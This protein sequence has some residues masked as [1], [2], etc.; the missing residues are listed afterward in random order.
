MSAVV[1]SLPRVLASTLVVLFLVLPVFLSLVVEA[2]HSPE[3]QSR[4]RELF[5]APKVL[6]EWLSEVGRDDLRVLLDEAVS[7]SNYSLMKSVV[8]R[9]FEYLG[10]DYPVTL[11][12]GGKHLIALKILNKSDDLSVSDRDLGWLL[13]H[14]TKVLN[15][16]DYSSLS[17]VLLVILSGL[18]VYG[19][20]NEL[21]YFMVYLMREPTA[22][23]V[24][25][26]LR[27]ELRLQI[28]KFLDYVESGAFKDA[29]DLSVNVS[30]S[31][32]I[33]LGSC[34]YLIATS[35]SKY[36]SLG[37]LPGGSYDTALSNSTVI[38]E[39]LE[40]LMRA[41]VS[42][43]LIDIL[44]RLPPEDLNRLLSD[45]N[46]LEEIDEEILVEEVSRYVRE[47]RYE[48]PAISSG[49]KTSSVVVKVFTV[50]SGGK[51]SEISYRLSSELS[52]LMYVISSTPTFS[53]SSGDS[54]ITQG[55]SPPSLRATSSGPYTFLFVAASSFIASLL[56]FLKFF[57]AGRRDLVSGVSRAGPVPQV[58]TATV[59]YVVR[60]FWPVVEGLCKLF[61]VSLGRHETHREVM[62][63]LLPKIRVFAGEDFTKLFSEL[64]KYY[65]LVR[66]GNVCEDEVMVSVARRVEEHVRGWKQ[67]S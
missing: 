27:N 2:R 3:L 53:S 54:G 4:S 8:S 24:S 60:A 34:M 44:K 19:D 42:S 31:T 28:L 46:R 38:K 66:F 52:P 50:V 64:T 6:T 25:E 56:F 62:S 59:P 9:V 63:K 21:S 14:A 61:K 39:L 36:A 35:Y 11:L 17:N 40:Y 49:S 13:Y 16:T 26:D 48:A 30:Y 67:S 15:K 12:V 58:G 37:K 20:H 45:I 10:S 18:V 33:L 32:S 47:R 51:S 22:S 43:P 23:V 57:P 41:N 29:A 7:T 55:A 1:S 65:E 5:E